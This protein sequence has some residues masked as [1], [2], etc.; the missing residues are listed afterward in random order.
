MMW[1]KIKKK[2]MMMTLV[3]VEWEQL[4]LKRGQKQWHRQQKQKRVAKS[5]ADCGI[6]KT[7]RVRL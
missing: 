7:M 6:V 2:K 3:A 4:R 5:E 1:R